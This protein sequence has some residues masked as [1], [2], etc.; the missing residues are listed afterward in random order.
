MFKTQTMDINNLIENILP[1][2]CKF[3]FEVS[4]DGKCYSKTCMLNENE[5]N[6]K[7]IEKDGCSIYKKF[8]T[9]DNTELKNK[10]VFNALKIYEALN[11]LEL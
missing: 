8:I 1:I 10:E 3:N 2:N 6:V 9:E 7:L 4:S 11:N 5:E